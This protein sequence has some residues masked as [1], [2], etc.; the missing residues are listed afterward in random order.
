M[1]N[2][3][4]GGAQTI[5]TNMS[6]ASNKAPQKLKFRAMFLFLAFFP[7]TSIFGVHAL[8]LGMGV[9]VVIIKDFIAILYFLLCF[10]PITSCS[11]SCVVSAGIVLL[12]IG[13][14]VVLI[15]YLLSIVAAITVCN[16]GKKSGTMVNGVFQATPPVTISSFFLPTI[17]IYLFI[18]FNYGMMIFTSLFSH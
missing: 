9:N 10:S 14:L 2:N 12:F 4:I 15:D 8:Y 13:L 17:V 7:P 6:P 5:T 18:I 16:T 11:G 1:K 3:N